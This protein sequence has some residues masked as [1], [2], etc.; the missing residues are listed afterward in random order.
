MKYINGNHQSTFEPSIRFHG[1]Q[2][3]RFVY[4][5]ATIL[6]LAEEKQYANEENDHDN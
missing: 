6:L 2:N 1:M 5:I 3:S 4:L